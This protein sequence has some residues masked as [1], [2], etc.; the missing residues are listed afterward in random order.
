MSLVRKESC[1][2][3]P[4]GRTNNPSHISSEKQLGGL[5]S[6]QEKSEVAVLRHLLVEVGS[7]CAS[8]LLQHLLKAEGI[9]LQITLL[10]DLDSDYI[11]LKEGRLPQ[12]EQAVL[13][14]LGI[15]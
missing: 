5:E 10:K 3:S 15:S 1:E 6:L 2:E 14:L 7:K 9:F 4:Q 12:L 11:K 13:C 8:T